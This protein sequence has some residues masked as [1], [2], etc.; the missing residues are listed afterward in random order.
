ML[1]FGNRIAVCYYKTKLMNKRENKIMIRR[2]S[3]FR[4][5]STLAVAL[6]MLIGAVASPAF[7]ADTTTATN[8]GAGN[9]MKISPV[10]TELTLKPGQSTTVDVF[11]TNVTGETTTFQ[12]IINDFVASGD[13]SG[14]PAI[15]LN[16]N[17]SAPSHGLKQY[18]TPIGNVTL[19][20]GEQAD[21]KA[22]INLPANVAP[23]GYYGAVR[24]APASSG[25]AKNISLSAVIAHR[26]DIL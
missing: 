2:R 13:E 15:I 7:A 11:I 3:V 9:G 5:I 20:P 25:A 1:S 26:F 17:Q 10:H 22:V 19:K 18:I 8:S 6:A 12:A 21:V 24:F 4:P 14:N 16:P 23:G